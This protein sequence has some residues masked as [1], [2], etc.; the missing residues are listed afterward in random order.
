[1]I[2]AFFLTIIFIVSIVF[3]I[4]WIFSP[5]YKIVFTRAQFED[6]LEIVE[7]LYTLYEK[8]KKAVIK[9]PQCILNAKVHSY[10]G[11]DRYDY[12]VIFKLIEHNYLNIEKTARYIDHAWPIL[13]VKNTED[14]IDIRIS[15]WFSF[16]TI[17][18]LR[19]L[20]FIIYAV[21]SFVLLFSI[22]MTNLNKFF[23]NIWMLSALVLSIIIIFCSAWL[24]S[25]LTTIIFLKRILDE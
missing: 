5:R 10:L 4:K 20:A 14:G 6:K 1:M 15:H 18:I 11:T 17:K 24:G 3:G 19:N 12:R 2:Y 23:T 9:E 25:K 21:S 22:L 7:K 8:H 13:N 16:G